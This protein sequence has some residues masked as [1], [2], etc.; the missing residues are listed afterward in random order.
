M[1]PDFNFYVGLG[2]KGKAF[3][4]LGKSLLEE[5]FARIDLSGEGLSGYSSVDFI[6]SNSAKLN[7]PKGCENFGKKSISGF[8]NLDG[9]DM[10][11]FDLEGEA[12]LLE[13]VKYI[14]FEYDANGGS[15]E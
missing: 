3:G 4:E 13:L 8:L 2:S 14:T 11:E 7:L 9:M 5:Q 6:P 1:I 10:S 12:K 15:I